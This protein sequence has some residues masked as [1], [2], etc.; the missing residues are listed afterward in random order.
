MQAVLLATFTHY[1]YM[2][3]LIVTMLMLTRMEFKVTKQKSQEEE[4]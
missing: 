3:L 4:E 1:G 2:D